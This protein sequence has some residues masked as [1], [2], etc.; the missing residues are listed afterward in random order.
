[1]RAW[2]P[3]SAGLAPV[4]LIGG[5]SVAASRQPDGYDSVRETISALAARG[6]TDRWIMTAGLA[7]LGLCHVATAA[8]FGEIGPGSRVVLGVG[9]VA[10]T[11]VAALPQPNAAHVP[12]AT[13]GFVA[14]AVWPCGSLLS[15]RRARATAVVVLMCLLAWL[16]VELH[17]GSLLGLSE[18]VLAGA[19]ALAP[20]AFAAAVLGRR[21][22]ASVADRR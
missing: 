19:E 1:M 18:R 20:L 15:F 21:T 3:V 7:I 22:C 10:T 5:W 6:A 11:L 17:G 16:A 2:V 4:A 14:L 12:V 13:V 8:G 9:G